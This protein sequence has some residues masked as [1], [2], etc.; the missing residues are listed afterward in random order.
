MR[1]R[2]VSDQKIFFPRK[3]TC[4][5]CF[6]YP[7]FEKKHR[8]NQYVFLYNSKTGR[9]AGYGAYL[10]GIDGFLLNSYL[11]NRKNRFLAPEKCPNRPEKFF[12]V[13]KIFFFF[14]KK[15]KIFFFDC[16]GHFRRGDFFFLLLGISCFSKKDLFSEKEKIRRFDGFRFK[17]RCRYGFF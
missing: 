5:F 6:F 3:K 16:R 2:S 9:L 4:F 1:S 11:K 12:W 15:K 13:F 8:N 10:D 17:F 14:S 7:K